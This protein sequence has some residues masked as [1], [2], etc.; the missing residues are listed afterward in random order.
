ML[1]STRPPPPAVQRPQELV[2]GW[3]EG[4]LVLQVGG[5]AAGLLLVVVAYHVHGV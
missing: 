4:R 2:R 3:L 5:A 1:N